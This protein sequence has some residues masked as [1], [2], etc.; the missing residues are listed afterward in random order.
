MPNGAVRRAWTR[1][2]CEP[3]SDRNCGGFGSQRPPMNDWPDIID[4]TPADETAVTAPA[5]DDRLRRRRISAVIA[6]RRATERSRAWRRLCLA[7]AA[8]AVIHVTIVLIRAGPTRAKVLTTAAGLTITTV[9]RLLAGQLRTVRPVISPSSLPLSNISGLD[10][11]T[12]WAE[13]LDRMH[14]P[15]DETKNMSGSAELE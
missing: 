14:H 3:S 4:D 9:A 12:D 6:D 11:R 10:D 2:R 15:R 1:T 13:N 7:V 8:V 5:E